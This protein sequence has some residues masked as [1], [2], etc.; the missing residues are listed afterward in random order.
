MFGETQFVKRE[1]LFGGETKVFG[2]MRT[3]CWTIILLQTIQEIV[4][5][6]HLVCKSPMIQLQENKAL[7]QVG[8]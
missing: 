3:V 6:W 7:N 8:Y 4:E 5:I 1:I 2:M